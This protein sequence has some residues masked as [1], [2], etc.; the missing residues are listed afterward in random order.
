VFVLGHSVHRFSLLTSLCVAVVFGA[1]CGARTDAHRSIDGGPVMATAPERCNGL[2]DDG[3]NGVDDPFRDSRGRY[4]TDAHCGACNAVCAPRSAAELSTRCQVV[5]EVPLCVAERCAA[6]FAPTHQGRCEALDERLCLPCANDNDCGSLSGARCAS[7][8]GEARCTVDCALGCPSG[9]RC[10]SNARV[11]VPNGGSC[12]CSPSDTFELACPGQTGARKP[13]APVCVGRASCVKGV[14]SA[15]T[16]GVE[17]CD[18]DDND[19]DDKVDEGFADARGAYSLDA[20]NC[21]ECGVSCL[22]DTGTELDLA[23]GGDPFAPTCTLACPDARDGVG[24]GDMLD[25]DLDIATGCE[26]KVSALRDAPGPLG[27]S[28]AELDVNC[29]GADGDVLSSFFVATDGDDSFA[30]SPTRPL[31]T[32]GAAVKRARASLSTQFARPHVFVAAGTYTETVEL[33]DGVLIHG[34]FRRD[35]R[36]ADPAAYVTE[37]RAPADTKAPGGAALIASDVGL[38]PTLVEG[39]SLRGLDASAI[40]R[41]TLGAYLERPQSGLTLRSLTIQAGVPGE[42]ITGLDGPAGSP[43]MSLANAGGPPR[44][45]ME[46]SRE[47]N[48]VRGSVNLVQGGGGGLN[49]CGSVDVRGGSGGAASCPQVDA[50]GNAAFQGA[51]ERG[52]AP[53]SLA[54]SGGMGGQDAHGPI[55]RGSGCNQAVCCGLADFEVPSDYQGPGPG[56]NGGDGT[57][58]AAGVGCADARGRFQAGLW[59]G[60]RG[61]AGQSGVPG[62]GGGGGGAGGGVLM[63]FMAGVCEFADGLGG[64]GGGGGA[65]GCG[66]GAGRE[67]T[68]GAPSVALLLVNP[69]AFV[70]S[71]TLLSTQRGG[72]GGPGGAGGDGGL[73]GVGANGGLVPPELRTTPTLAGTYPGARGGSGGAG[74]PGG[75][76]GGGC[77]GSSVGIWIVGSEPSTSPGWRMANRFTLGSGGDGGAGGGGAQTGSSGARGETLD[78]LVQQ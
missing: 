53:G 72:R 45:A 11:C 58:G 44:A 20:A 40:E 49:Q 23:C 64:G 26:C 66:G 63:D 77:G 19:C 67:G 62:S 6:G 34:G 46:Q 78:V 48:C 28:G 7:I 51:G 73:G 13:G 15:C 9:Y 71:D 61:S 43:P 47:R 39:L 41:A 55:L 36:A 14:L 52:R 21:G 33:A 68:S 57:L 74:G 70:L 2:D 4:V 18:H 50:Q 54:G 76:G 65:G 56:S 17:V 27:K 8:G 22:E 24:V 12:S 32:I 10:D 38:T 42:G 60:I 3:V 59:N 35:F 69:G 30:G 5:D 25:G 29:D 75:G 1:G 16:T 37:V 31:R